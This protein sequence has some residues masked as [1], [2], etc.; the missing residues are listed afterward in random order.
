MRQ[1]VA[2]LT[3]GLCTGLPAQVA[4][5]VPEAPALIE[6]QIET[7]IQT[8]TPTKTQT[9]AHN[10]TQTNTQTEPQTQTETQ[11]PSAIPAV[12]SAGTTGQLTYERSWP[13]QKVPYF[14]IAVRPDGSGLYSTHPREST[15]ASGPELTN[16]SSAPETQ[17][18]HL[19]ERDRARVFAAIPAI[20]SPKGC[21]SGNRHTA[22]TGR[23]VF[24]LEGAVFPGGDTAGSSQAAQC[25]FNFSDD[26]RI[27]EAVA[28]LNGIALTIEEANHLTYLLRFDRL[29]L[30]A[31]LGALLQDAEA[32]R[33]L[34]M[35]N[36]APLL[37][38]L[39]A[40]DALMTRVRERATTLLSLGEGKS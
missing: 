31:A 5:A 16:T 7:L 14:R 3:L 22:Q 15:S 8:Q 30:D 40:D 36:I 9:S 34:E 23:K 38:K 18:I 19:S 39:Q 27:E 37:N 33:A 13:E 35:Q 10:P 28:T 4:I 29:G 11:A 24:S 26:H 2:L 21:D 20:R 32:G 1:A 6:V 17:Q 25:T 12:A